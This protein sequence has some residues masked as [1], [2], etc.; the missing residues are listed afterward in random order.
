MALAAKLQM[1]PDQSVALVNAPAD[2]GGDD[3]ADHPDAPEARADPGERT[4]RRG[5][6]KGPGPPGQLF[7]VG[8]EDEHEIT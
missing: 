3:L 8:D 7:A 5:G 2:L 6:T 1:R 4:A